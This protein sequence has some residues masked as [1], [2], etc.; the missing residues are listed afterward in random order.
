MAT[1]LPNTTTTAV[2]EVPVTPA[3]ALSL[4]SRL[5]FSAAHATVTA[6]LLLAGLGGLYRCG[7][8]LGTA[9]W[10]INYKR[11]RRFA[12]ALA[13]TVES[14]PTA[15]ER[16]RTTLRYFQRSRCDK[17]F[18]L[19][20]DRI[21]RAKAERLLTISNGS[22]LDEAL[23][24]GRGTYIAMSH[25]GAHHVGA[26]LMALRGYKIAGVR[27]RNEGGLRRYV[28]DRFD[29]RYPDFCR[30]RVLFSDSYPRDI[31]RCF[32]EGYLVGSAMDVARPPT[33]SQKAE[34]VAV[35][36][37]QRLFLSGPLRVA[38]RCGAPVVQAFVVSE[39]G[40]RY[41][42]DIVDR[43]IDPGGAHDEEAAVAQAIQTYA[44]NVE[45]YLRA[46]PSAISRI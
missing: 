20:F 41:R 45:R 36:G 29:R 3:N 15:A 25:H 31:Y 5:S 18:Y 10:L 17:L 26:M 40:F 46:D 23:A 37:E 7:R 32:R 19:I 33:G 35:F 16:R 27:D 30:M 39:P 42:L 9:E 1:G 28:Q 11:R 6:L 21:P 12:Q 14:P 24:T 44:A 13:R 22:L 38:I 2:V 43:L 4:G 34:E 8:L